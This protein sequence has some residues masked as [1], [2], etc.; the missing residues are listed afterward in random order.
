M[1]TNS[2]ATALERASRDWL[3]APPPASEPRWLNRQ[4]EQAREF[5]DGHGLPRSHDESFRF[6]PLA[7]VT[8]QPLQMANGSGANGTLESSAECIASIGFVDGFPVGEPSD[9][10]P[11]LSIERLADALANDSGT[12]QH[13]LG[14]VAK[15]IHGFAAVGLALFH[16]AW[17]VRVREGTEV[18]LPLE[19]VVRQAQTGLW[20]IPRLLVVLEPRSRLSIVERQVAGESGG[21]GLSTAIFEFIVGDGATLNHVRLAA[22]SDSEA[23]LSLVSAEVQKNGHYHSWVGSLGGGLTRLDTR[24]H[25]VGAGARVDLDGLYMARHRELVDHHTVVYHES[26]S[27]TATETYR[28]I[29]DD[30]ALAVFDGLIVVKPGAQQTNAQ[31]YNRNLVLS[32]TAV[33]HTKPQLE[34]EAD[35]VVCNHGATVGRLDAQQLFYLQSRGLSASLAKQLLMVAFANELIDRCPAAEFVPAIRTQVAAHLGTTGDLDW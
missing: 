30:E 8:A 21:S 25:L 24:V 31:Q 4:R 18:S 20:S 17:I 11:G 27:T 33:V 19:V 29:L 23:E 16:D 35:D 13:H 34:I 5:F 14:R 32:D 15:P 9:L 1:T 10:S 2:Q 6:L 12:I 26:P 7:S 22:R 28:G 3:R